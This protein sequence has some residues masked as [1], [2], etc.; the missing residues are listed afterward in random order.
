M[1]SE[2]STLLSFAKDGASTAGNGDAYELGLQRSR[3]LADA[4][5]A[6]L[7][8]EVRSR[9]LL[10]GMQRD[11]A[12]SFLSGLLIGQDVL[13][14]L[15]LLDGVRGARTSLP[16]IGTGALMALYARALAIHG[17]H[18]L[19]LD[20]AEVTLAGLRTLAF[21]DDDP[22]AHSDCTS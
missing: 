13:G 9:Q 4:P 12:L 11:E 8:F 3:E 14:A 18:G 17:V 16:L 6:H 2:R 22:G 20:A 15:P 10:G 21:S 7:L 5:L 1:L 19:P